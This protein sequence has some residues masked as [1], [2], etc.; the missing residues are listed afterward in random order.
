MQVYAYIDRKT[1]IIECLFP[2]RRTPDQTR[3][4]DTIGLIRDN[5]RKEFFRVLLAYDLQHLQNLVMIRKLTGL[6]FRIDELSV[7]FDIEDTPV[8]FD[9]RYCNIRKLF[10][11]LCLQTGGLGIIVSDNAVFDR[12]FHFI[13]LFS[14]QYTLN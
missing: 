3:N 12:Y 10:L 7:R 13:L 5:S 8:T 2:N 4:K 14:T 9:Q 6:V 11:D 1:I